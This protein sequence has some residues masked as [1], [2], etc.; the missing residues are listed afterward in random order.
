[1]WLP[2][3]SEAARQ[4]A[5]GMRMSVAIIL[6]YGIATRNL[7]VIINA[8][9]ALAVTYLPALLERD[10][11]VRL[12]PELTFVVTLAVSL[13]TLGMVGLYEEV[14]WYDHLTHTLSAMLVAAVGY[15]A[16]RAID[17]HSEE[18][19]FPPRFLSLFLLLFTL[20]LGVFW[21]VLEFAARQAAATL[22][23]EAVLVQYGLEDTILD[24][25]FD[26]VGAILVALFGTER[27]TELTE[28]LRERLA[29]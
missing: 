19:S 23:I 10:W 27:L 13:H 8:V 21:E 14:W 2:P 28:Q 12:S 25:V 16:T 6:G 17:L 29:V 24:L 3:R 5:S 11:D 22:G 9:V 18:V 26:T 15:A 7:S 1:M 4:A 20:A